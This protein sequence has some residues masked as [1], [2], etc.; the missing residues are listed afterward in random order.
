[1]LPELGAG[2]GRRRG[3]RRPRWGR[4]GRQYRPVGASGRNALHRRAGREVWRLRQRAKGG[5]KIPPA[6]RTTGWRL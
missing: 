1:M 4:P 6:V 5:W 2:T 3:E